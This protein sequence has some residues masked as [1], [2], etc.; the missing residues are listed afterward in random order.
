MMPGTVEFFKNYPN[1]VFVET[2]SHI[3]EGIVKALDAGFPAV[4]SI[5]A[6]DK[7]YQHCLNRFKN[8]PRVKLWKGDSAY[9]LKDMIADLTFPV[10]FWLDGH[11]SAGDTCKCEHEHPLLF[12]LKQIS[13]HPVK[14]HI[15]LIDDWRDYS[16][17]EKEIRELAPKIIDNPVF[18]KVEDIFVVT[19]SKE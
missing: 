14:N 7:Q 19:P 17:W 5:D 13:E 11:Y 6:G 2:G 8:E 15:L 9:V 10:T 12:E 18:S 4:R 1:Q 3:G 16:L